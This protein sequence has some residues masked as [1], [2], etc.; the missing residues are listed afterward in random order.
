V[1][2]ALS[3]A[4]KGGGTTYYLRL[5]FI[6]ILLIPVGLIIA[7]S[8][9][10]YD[11]AF[12]DAHD[13]V[14]H[15]ADAIHEYALKVFETDELIL[16]HIAEHVS[17]MDWSVLVRSEEFHRYLQQFSSSSQVSSVG[18]IAPDHGL[19][20][21]NPLFPA[22]SDAIEAP[23]Y[24]PVERGGKQ[25]I[26]IGTAVLGTFVAAPQFSVVRTAPNPRS[27]G[28]NG[29]IFVSTKLSD[30]VEYYRSIADP[31]D[32]LVTMVRSDGAVLVRSP[33]EELVGRVLSP[34]S[35]FRQAI[36]QKP[37]GGSYDG[38]SDIDGVERLFAYR[39]LGPYPIYVVV[40]FKRS[41]VIAGWA[42]VMASQL[43]FGLPATLCLM[44]L[45][46]I[47]LRRSVV[48]DRAV[49]AAQAEV[50]RRE[51][52][53]ASLRQVQ[54]MEVV[55]QLTGG[56]AH[57]F[58]NLLTAIA[59]NLDLILRRSEDAARVRRLAE[60]ALQATQR[61]ER[62]TQQ[63]LVF[64]RRQV[65]R[66]ET[67]NLNRV[68]VDFEGLMAHAVSETIDLQFQL[69][70][71][72]DP[73]RIDR[74]QFEAALLNLV[75]NARDALPDGGR[76]TIE[77]QN[78]VLEKAYADQNPEVVPGAYVMLAVSDNGVGIDRSV[79]PHVF[80][81]FFTTKDVGKGSGL[82]LSQVYGFAEQSGGHVKIYSEVGIGTTVKL[83]LPK[84]TDRPVEGDRQPLI[85]L[86]NA[87][88]GETILV[89]E[90]DEAVLTMAVESLADLGYRVLVAHDGPE[91]LAIVNGP[92]RIDI[93]FSD[94]VMPGGINGAQLAIE[95]RRLRPG[96]KVLLTSG[97]TAAALSNEH[98]LQEELPVLSK[99]YR[100]DELAAQLRVIA[101]GLSS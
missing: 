71:A 68:L 48:A 99:P 91:A 60:A 96:I 74:S 72:L 64:S 29:V 58:N 26:Y 81:P 93:L 40:G 88:G 73:S 55:G 62:I 83:Y 45:A 89:V 69:D 6:A 27:A 33:G 9:L 52:A 7:S 92:E 70:A 80:E 47:A 75:V 98:G 59:G 94:I 82:G 30:F 19:A 79:L 97:Y 3:A 41:A 2:S 84:A 38:A 65:L 90:D 77:T 20:A 8:W 12:R 14:S 63:L 15:A 51:V 35:R 67:L 34:A 44:L 39:K 4:R 25:P 1:N 36:A 85:P 57:D 13:R 46:V 49:V 17:G 101:G 95:A 53:E 28:D 78:A 21:T 56:V 22:P 86:R 87:N 24:L 100:R 37:D 32:F 50:D 16:D 76:V 5:L 66:A 43:M 10:N 61:G 11:A 42:K 18:F 23:G 54:K 31:R